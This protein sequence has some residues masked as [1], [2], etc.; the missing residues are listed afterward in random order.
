MIGYLLIIFPQ[1]Y[2]D[3]SPPP[4]KRKRHRYLF[5]FMEGGWVPTINQGVGVGL[6]SA[7]GSTSSTRRRKSS[8]IGML[9]DGQYC[10]YHLLIRW[11]LF[12]YFRAPT[13][14]ESKCSLPAFFWFGNNVLLPPPLLIVWQHYSLSRTSKLK[15]KCTLQSD[16][17][18]EVCL[19]DY[20]G[21]FRVRNACEPKLVL[22]SS[23]INLGCLQPQPSRNRPQK[24]SGSSS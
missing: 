11:N 16:C 10:Y 18:K 13:L 14:L 6:G 20:M 2:H 22:P 24:L 23:T 9:S 7:A 4:Q 19:G 3:A 15:Q 21:P 1:C 8:K 5:W 12:T 17:P